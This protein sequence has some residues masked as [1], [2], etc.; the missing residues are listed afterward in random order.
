MNRQLHY[1]CAAFLGAGM[2]HIIPPYVRKTK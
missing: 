1:L 2:L